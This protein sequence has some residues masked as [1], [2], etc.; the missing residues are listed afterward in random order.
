MRLERVVVASQ[1]PDKVAEIETVL[2]ALGIGIEVVRDVVWPDVEETEPTL[3]GNALLKARV[4][5]DH[6]G[7]AALADDTGLEVAALGGGPG[8]R[9]ARFAGESARYADNVSKLLAAMSGSADR[10]ARFRTVIA[11]VDTE[12]NELVVEGVL[13]GSITEEPRG[14]GGFG[15]DPVFAVDDR[16]L[17]EMPSNEKNRVSHRARALRALADALQERGGSAPRR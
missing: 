17:A 6:T 11:V 13:D 1:N 10:T 8:V 4:V 16:T 7:L 15:Y 2:A 3:E 9:T 14:D 5:R 12:G